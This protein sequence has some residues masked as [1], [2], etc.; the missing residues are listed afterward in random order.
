MR[1]ESFAT[2]LIFNTKSKLTAFLNSPFI[3]PAER[4]RLHTIIRL[5]WCVNKFYSKSFTWFQIKEFI[6]ELLLARGG[7][8]GLFDG[9][10]LFGTESDDEE[11]DG[12]EPIVDDFEV[13]FE[14]FVGPLSGFLGIE[15][16]IKMNSVIFGNL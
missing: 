1:K 9:T 16:K 5:I 2:K 8:R 10:F 15:L 3:I 4:T 11:T 14:L 12:D 7:G 13:D 6:I